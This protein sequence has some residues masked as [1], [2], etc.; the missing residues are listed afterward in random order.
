MALFLSNDGVQQPADIIIGYALLARFSPMQF[1]L[2]AK[3][4]SLGKPT[5]IVGLGDPSDMAFFPEVGTF[6]AANSPSPVSAEAAVQVLFGD[7][8][9]GGRLPMP[10]GNIY[11][12][13]Y[14]L[15]QNGKN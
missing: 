8:Q 14:A 5:V 1:D 7:A 3:L 13:G 10:I 15:Q 11:P 4:I 9:A 2:I 6:V 12:I